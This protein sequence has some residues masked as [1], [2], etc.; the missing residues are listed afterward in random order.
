LGGYR[1][2]A[3]ALTPR[4]NSSTPWL[5]NAA[6]TSATVPLR[7]TTPFP[8]SSDTNVSVANDNDDF[9][10]PLKRYRLQVVQNDSEN[11]Q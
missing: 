2:R 4:G 10:T 3:V 11:Y 1:E 6:N 8:E 9:A 7:L 5:P